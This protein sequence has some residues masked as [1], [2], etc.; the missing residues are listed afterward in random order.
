MQPTDVFYNTYNARHLN[1]KEVAETFIWS[2]NYRKLIHNSHSVILGARGCGKTTLMK[3]LTLPALHAWTSDEATTIKNG[4]NFYAIY[5]STD[6]YWDVKN[7]TFSVELERFGD[8]AKLISEFAVNSNVFKALC[9]TFKNVISLDLKDFDVE[10]EYELSKLLINAWKLESTIPKLDYVIDSLNKR[11]DTVNQD[12]RALLF[13]GDPQ[14]QVPVKDFFY[15]NFETSI[16]YIIPIFERIYGISDNK[17]KWA[18]CF[19]ELEFAPKWLQQKLFVSLRSRAQ[20]LLY[21]LSASPILSSDLEG[22][23]LQE[24]GATP[25]NDLQIIKMWG[26]KQNEEFSHKLIASL[27]RK[28]YPQTTPERYFGS[29]NIYNKTSNSYDRGSDF[30]KEELSLLEKDDSF[31]EFLYK[32]DIDPKNPTP[33][34]DQQKDTIFR[35]I[36]P[37]VYFRNYYIDY[38]KNTAD[39]NKHKLRPRKTGDLYSGIE[40]LKKVCDGNPR[41][42]ILL[43]TSILANSNENGADKRIQYNELLAASKRFCNMIENIPIAAKNNYTFKQVLSKIGAFF[44][45]DV[46]GPTF[47]MEPRTTFTVDLDKSAESEQ[48]IEILEKGVSQ[49]AFIILDTEDQGFDFECRGQRFKL[50]YL[51]S[52][53]YKLPLRRNPVASLTDI[54]YKKDLNQ[55][56]SD[57]QL[58]IF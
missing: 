29:N 3:M 2:D 50:S 11:I 15:L 35:K 4:I 9:E 25:G 31:K 16:E 27:I 42:L 6:I 39:G 7:Q 55:I 17:K 38:N 28:N 22:L 45:T 8:Y 54:I 18:L 52:I 37:V 40:V 53:Q 21:K 32:Y 19:D 26:S 36:K 51:L 57:T 13:N 33:T 5:I 49:G 12:V 56:T 1:P 30:Y 20:F 24:Y 14:K 46:L 44:N 10:K 43:I 48:I 58:E 41:W 23:F 34:S 47:L